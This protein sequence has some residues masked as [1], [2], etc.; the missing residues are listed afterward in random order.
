MT[1]TRRRILSLCL[2]LALVAGAM[3][4]AV[5]AASG[6]PEQTTEPERGTM[7]YTEPIAP[8][9][10]AAKLFSEGLAAV[11]Q[12]G[13]WGYIATDGETAIPF[14]YDFACPFSEG[15]AV[16]GREEETG[17]ALGFVDHDGNY[18]PFTGW[19][20][21]LLVQSEDW[22]ADTDCYFYNG[23]VRLPA[24]AG[25]ALYD[26]AGQ[27]MGAQ[28]VPLHT[29]TEGLTP[30]Y[31]AS[32][33]LG[34]GYVDRDGQA[35]LYWDGPE[36]FGAPVTTA[37]G[38]RAQ[39]YRFVSGVLP[40]NQGLAPVWQ[41]TADASQNWAVTYRLG[42]IDQTGEWAILPAYTNCFVSGSD[43]AWEVFGETGLAMVQNEAGLYGAIDQTGRTV[44][45]FQYQE[46]WPYS[47]GLAPFRLGG[48]YGYLNPSGQTAIPARYERAT[49]FSG[50]YAAVY[51]GERA[52][53]IDRRGRE[54]TG[55]D[56]LDTETYFR[57]GADGTKT[58]VNPGEYVVIEEGGQYGFGRLEFLPPLPEAGEMD[59]WAYGEVVAAVEADL[60]PVELQ[61]LYRQNITRAQFCTL[62]V[63]VVQRSEGKDIRTVVRE[64]TGRSL[65]DWVGDYPFADTAGA[66][67]MAAYALGIVSGRGEGTFD[68][69]APITRQEAAAF[70]YRTAK[71]LG[72][73]TAGAAESAFADHDQVGVWFR[74]AVAFAADRGV[75]GS[76]GA[77]RF[78]P[79]AGYTREQSFVT[80]HR[81]FQAL[82]GEE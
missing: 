28:L 27:A 82:E 32:A 65:Y 18:T 71:V 36:Y 64:E 26:A 45:P 33:R 78:S 10:E 80:V 37:D 11:R 7:T 30:G 73:E 81:L 53:L 21:P 19:G 16:V 9:Y 58:A 46:L 74:D 24:G 1:R 70:L 56:K 23:F 77:N 20:K 6:E 63:Q 31:S 39:S 51:D 38:L 75:M 5:Q 42:F 54:V 55:S 40:F 8:Q 2:T 67:V 72:M 43:A 66:D 59:A 12:G 41:G 35:V 68:P 15:K 3:A 47:E 76:T 50:G 29:M 57:E 34:R 69:Y 14:A 4:A 48:K 61:C 49:G 13:K 52:F 79:L 62:I 22:Q 60:V 25:W 44:L 17:L